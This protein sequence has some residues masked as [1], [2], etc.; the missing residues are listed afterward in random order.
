MI[1]DLEPYSAYKDSGV[2]W[3]G[4]VPEGWVL[5][6]GKQLF[7]KMDR[8]VR[9]TD[10]TVTCFRDGMVTLR[11]IRRTAG[12]TEAIQESGYQGVRRGDLVIHQMDA[13]AGAVGVSD[14]DGKASPVYA[15][16][17]SKGDVDARYYQHVVRQMARSGWIAALAKGVR[18][19]STDFRFE[20]FGQQILPSPSPGEQAAIAD[21]LT[22]VDLRI[23]RVIAAK[24]RLVELLEE[25]KLAIVHRAAMHGL[26]T[27]DSRPRPGTDWLRG[28][29]NAWR[30]GRLS[31]SVSSTTGG[32]WGGE[33]NGIDDVTCVR[34]ADF[35]RQLRVV[36]P[37]PPT[38]RALPASERRRRGLMKGDLL[39]EKSGGGSNQPVG[40]V[41]LFDHSV[42]AVPSNF[43]AR[44]RSAPG[45]DPKYL[46]YL[47][48]S[49]YALRLNARSVKQT[50][51][52]QNLD[53][54]AYLSEQVAF[55]PLSE[56]GEIADYLDR[57]VARIHAAVCTTQAEVGLLREYRTRLISDV[58]TGKL[59]VR[60][61]VKSIPSDPSAD[62]PALDEQLEEVAAA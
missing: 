40:T 19:R 45:Y 53:L 21:F 13:F 41:V 29:P 9:E 56:Q 23:Q 62:D 3:L 58:V 55:P 17:V 16:C 42:E 25:E 26:N 36:R 44:V 30:L 4:E 34:V 27:N 5:R 50:T 6:R 10:E 37:D 33:A 47:H 59:D 54:R 43:I 15:V 28:V 49:L 38:L 32:A 18:E 11:R 46:L 24:K 8:K 7:H 1:S 31:D 57:E 48:W 14:S 20:T 52:I 51:G 22:Y 61:A 39:I 2:E 12:F 35:D 60:E